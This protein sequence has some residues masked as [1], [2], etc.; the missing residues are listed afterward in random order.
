M[1]RLHHLPDSIISLILS[2]LI[3]HECRTAAT[4]CT[5]LR[6]CAKEPRALLTA[7]GTIRRFWRWYSSDSR[8]KRLLLSLDTLY[9]VGNRMDEQHHPSIW[10]TLAKRIKTLRGKVRRVG[11][12]EILAQFDR[13]M[14][15]RHGW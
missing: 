12:A 10:N 4:T 13:S 2:K 14:H 7:A 3:L 8:V 1:L 5:C 6:E 9:L 15:A 11:G